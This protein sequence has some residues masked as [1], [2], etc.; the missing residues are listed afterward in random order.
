MHDS[1]RRFKTEFFKA[2]AHPTRIRIL[3]L[4]RAG[5]MSVNELQTKLEIE[6]SGVSQQLA[7]LRNRNIV[8]A[9]KEGTSVY[10]R[11]RDPQVFELL[12][13]AR[14]IF[15]AALI[16]TQSMLEQLEEEGASED[17]PERTTRRAYARAP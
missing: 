7:V 9:R 6:S 10:Y 11:V 12:D 14:R 8:E 1:L 2:L 13:V 5:E 4:L 3:E 15:N 16:D 17:P